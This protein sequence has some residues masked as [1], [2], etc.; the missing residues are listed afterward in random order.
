MGLADDVLGP[1]PEERREEYYSQFKV[2]AESIGC[3]PDA[4][5]ETLA[6]FRAYWARTVATLEIT[7]A[8]REQAAKVLHPGR[9][10]LL[11]PALPLARFVTIGLLPEQIRADY[12]YGWDD[13][14]QRIFDGGRALT[15]RVYPLI[16]RR[17]REVPKEFYLRGMRRRF[18]RRRT[19]TA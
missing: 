5:P 10:N 14:R 13:R 16:P 6:D 11:T 7:P 18:A 19:A 2:V 3:P 9:L 8:A 12:G 4:Q 15:R 17:L 1:F